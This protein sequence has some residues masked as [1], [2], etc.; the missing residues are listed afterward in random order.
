MR[1]KSEICNVASKIE[2]FHR[3]ADMESKL[4]EIDFKIQKLVEDKILENVKRNTNA[5]ETIYGNFNQMK[6]WK[7]KQNIFRSKKDPPMAKLDQG[8][9]LISSEVALKALYIETYRRR[10]EHKPMIEKH[11][12]IYQLKM[13]LWQTRYKM[14]KTKKTREW[15]VKEVEMA[16]KN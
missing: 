7:L 13:K 16:V 10:L 4:K 1:E 6:L 9:N 3:R 12:E 15:T 8:G 11:Q 5:S 14:L 2:D